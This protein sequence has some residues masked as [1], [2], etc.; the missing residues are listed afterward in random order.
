MLNFSMCIP[1][2]GNSFHLP[3]TTDP[4]LLSQTNSTSI[5]IILPRLYLPALLGSV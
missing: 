5:R 4:L 1:I 3:S 2:A